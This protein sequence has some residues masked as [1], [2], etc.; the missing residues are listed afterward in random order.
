MLDSVGLKA[1]SKTIGSDDLS[2]PKILRLS[3]GNV[4]NHVLLG[5][6]SKHSTITHDW[7]MDEYD[8][9]TFSFGQGQ[10]IQYCSDTVSIRASGR[11]LEVTGD[12]SFCQYV[13]E[14]K[15]SLNHDRGPSLG[16]GRARGVKGACSKSDR[17]LF[18]VWS[19]TY[20]V[21]GWPY[22]RMGWTDGR[23]A[24]GALAQDA[25][26]DVQPSSRDWLNLLARGRQARATWNWRCAAVRICLEFNWC[27][28]AFNANGSSNSIRTM[29]CVGC[30]GLRVS[31]PGE[32]RQSDTSLFDSR[33]EQLIARSH[34]AIIS[35]RIAR[36]IEF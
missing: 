10:V 25:V 33:Q 1:I 6:A 14:W 32:K 17:M 26:R 23:P 20:D 31:P 30:Q 7:I 18:R 4:V 22:E 19:S 34:P 3:K 9:P 35:S 28:M 24:T 12:S 8:V 15:N 21:D 11:L 29:G 36:G 16:H 2:A 13:V 5:T 27:F